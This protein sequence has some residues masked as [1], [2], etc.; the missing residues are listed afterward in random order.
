MYY[1][2][3]NCIFVK[4]YKIYSSG[5]FELNKQLLLL[6]QKDELK[7]KIIKTNGEAILNAKVYF[8]TSLKNIISRLH[9]TGFPS[10]HATIVTYQRQQAIKKY[11]YGIA[12]AAIYDDCDDEASYQLDCL[13]YIF[14]KDQKR[15]NNAIRI[16]MNNK[17][18]PE[19][20]HRYPGS[21]PFCHY[22]LRD[23]DSIFSKFPGG[24]RIEDI[25]TRFHVLNKIYPADTQVL[26]DFSG[27]IDYEDFDRSV[28]ARY[29]DLA[30]NE[31]VRYKLGEKI[32]ILTEGSSD[33]SILEA[34]LS[35]LYPEM[36]DYF[37]FKDFPLSKAQGGVGELAN[38]IRKF[39]GVGVRTKIIAL[40]DNDTAGLEA[41]E[42]LDCENI[43]NNISILFLPELEFAKKYPIENRNDLININGLA[44]GIELYLGE[45]VIKKNGA[46]IPVK[47][48]S[49]SNK[50][51]TP[52]GEICQKR[53]I[54]KRFFD[55]INRIRKDPNLT[56]EKDWSSLRLIFQAIFH[57]CE[58]WAFNDPEDDYS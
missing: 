43:P 14:N 49:W 48:Y 8:E 35:I 11:E 13:N 26:Y 57:V 34:S 9:I 32:V 45:D 31:K 58:S 24:N 20:A 10:T 50:M 29:D 1:N 30:I 42:K 19:S 46:F 16:L 27:L 36:E 51:N 52:F 18:Y 38:S 37:C 54:Q 41:A 47:L 4:E 22:L 5:E 21:N 33:T 15:F 7:V 40:F 6:F 17:V 44:C 2:E 55:W 23:T 3:T 39:S 25:Y 28:Y 53:I 12:K 56:H